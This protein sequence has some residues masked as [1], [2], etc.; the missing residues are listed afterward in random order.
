[1]DASFGQLV[2]P[3][4]VLVSWVNTFVS[5]SD[6]WLSAVMRTHCLITKKRVSKT[7]AHHLQSRLSTGSFAVELDGRR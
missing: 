6:Q 1:M 2:L 5:L 3:H 7:V 4:S